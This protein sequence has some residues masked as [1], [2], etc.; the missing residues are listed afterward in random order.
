VGYWSSGG[1]VRGG[2]RFDI[3]DGGNP[4]NSKYAFLLDYLGIAFLA[5]GSNST[6]IKLSRWR[7]VCCREAHRLLYHSRLKKK[8]EEEEREVAESGE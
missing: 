4:A 8:K 2:E 6:M 5:G 7:V 1:A 3:F